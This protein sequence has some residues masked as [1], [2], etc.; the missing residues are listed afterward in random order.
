[1]IC[2]RNDPQAQ[3]RKPKSKSRVRIQVLGNIS[4]H[5]RSITTDRVLLIMNKEKFV[6]EDKNNHEKPS[7]RFDW[8]GSSSTR[9]TTMRI[10][11]VI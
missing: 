11:C 7:T 2:E 1:M 3:V 8:K 4:G 5:I 10:S 6:S 9:L